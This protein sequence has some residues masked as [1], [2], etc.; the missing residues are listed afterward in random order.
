MGN[1]GRPTK[2]KEEFNF[3][4]E[5]LCKLGATDKEI[6]DFFDVEESTINNW[7]IEYPEFLESIKAGKILADTNVA[8]AL[9]HRAIGYEHEDVDIR[10]VDKEIVQT[11][12]M[13]YYPPDPTAIIFWLKN[14]Q[15]AKWRDKNEQSIEH[16]GSVGFDGI[17]VIRPNVQSSDAEV[18]P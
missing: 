2:F 1:V 4:V 11:S 5:K 8:Q 14:R 13:K 3:Q 17:N 18:H 15:S 9:Y 10:V 16:S 6:A 12:L 7:K